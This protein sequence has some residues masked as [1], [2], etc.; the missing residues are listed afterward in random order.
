MNN[1]PQIQQIYQELKKLRENNEDSTLIYRKLYK[2]LTTL[3]NPQED[4][5]LSKVLSEDI[6]I[7]LFDESQKYQLKNQFLAL[8]YICNNEKIPNGILKKSATLSNSQWNIEKESLFDNSKKVF[9]E[10]IDK[11]NEFKKSL[12]ESYMKS[13]NS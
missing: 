6:E 13:G 5:D 10:K 3:I 12:I 7:E 4:L 9:L 2:K 1:Q 11:N 8:K